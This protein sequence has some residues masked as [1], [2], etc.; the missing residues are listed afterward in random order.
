MYIN[1]TNF[2][3]QNILFIQL[4]NHYK[5]KQLIALYKHTLIDTL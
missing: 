5:D 4:Y 1:K 2:D 3:K